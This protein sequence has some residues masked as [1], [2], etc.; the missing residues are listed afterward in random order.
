MIAFVTGIFTGFLSTL[1][2]RRATVCA[3]LYITPSR[4]FYP[5]SPCG[6]RHIQRDVRAG[7]YHFYPRSPCGERRNAHPDI[8]LPC[9]IS[10]H[11]LLAE[12]DHINTDN[13]SRV[14]L[15]LS[16]LS[17]RRAT[18]AAQGV[19]QRLE[20]LSTLSLRRA[21]V[22]GLPH[23]DDRGI[24]IHAL[25]AES[26]CKAGRTRRKMGHFYPRS[27]CG[28]RLLDRDDDMTQ[29]EFLSTLSLRRATISI[30]C[31]TPS[32]QFLS[33]LSLRR[34]TAAGSLDGRVRDISI[35]ALLAESD[36][37]LPGGLN[38]E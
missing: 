14:M 26:D 19:L 20:F 11:A 34:A 12:S 31:I 7:T 9:A 5:R 28:E 17:L 33:T 37:A 38:R 24:S 2:L 4:N 35:H 13:F 8:R 25:L 36:T 22:H 30:Q 32:G 18:T 15:F 16:T 27:P 6:E 10:I 1:S 3:L 23:A 29:L 21:T